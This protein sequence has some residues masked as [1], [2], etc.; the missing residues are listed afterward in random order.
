M[1]TGSRLLIFAATQPR[2]RPVM[3]ELTPEGQQIVTDA[4]Q[5]HRVSVD[6]VLTLLRALVVGH[7]TMAQFNHPELGGMGQ[8]T[9]G[10][11]TMVGS[12]FDHG[13]KARV[14]ALCTELAALLCQQPS[15]M[16]A[17][18]SQAHPQPSA[19]GVSLFV[20]GAA[21]SSGIWWPPELG[22]PSSAGS[23]ADLRYAIFPAAHRLAIERSGQI[24][25]YDTQDHLIAG[26]SQQQGADQSLRFVSQHGLVRLDDLPV[27]EAGRRSSTPDTTRKG[28]A[29]EPERVASMTAGPAPLKSSQVSSEDIFATLERLAELHKNGVLTDEEFAAKKAELLARI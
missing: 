22:Q 17:P 28:I 23:Q 20:A 13:L 10:G 2:A 4:A 15:I 19:P 14:D 18:G 25:F 8:W 29:T 21:S 6:A 16:A 5:R 27:V 11:M 3:H 7:G 9:Q 1:F 12:L 26:V 24:T